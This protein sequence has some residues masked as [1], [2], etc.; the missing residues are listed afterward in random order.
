[1]PPS[2]IF[3]RTAAFELSVATSR[4]I[5]EKFTQHRP[6][7]GLKILDV[8]CRNGESVR[9][10]TD[11]GAQAYGVDIAPRCIA[12][13]QARFPEL[14]DRYFV[15]DL[16]QLPA[17]PQADFDLVLCVGVL[18]YTPPEAWLLALHGMAALCRPG[19]EV[20]VLL[21]RQKSA[22]LR[23]AVRRLSSL[24][25]G[26]FATVIAPAV[27]AAVWPMSRPLL[28]AAMSP[29]EIHYRVSLS[30]Y[31]LHFGVPKQLLPYEFPIEASAYVSPTLSRG[32][33]IPAPAPVEWAAPAQ[34][35][36]APKS[37]VQ[38]LV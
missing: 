32:F 20:R 28:G 37:R 3:D 30:L 2:P 35:G 12:H 18:P 9:A 25:E 10:L 38:P 11:I 15:G 13:A 5:L 34:A 36:T 7:A 4:D 29:A 27:T 26:V 16:R 14:A 31:G 21:Q 22:A 17:L 23:F 19:G 1:M 24:P 8:G 6:L 33:A